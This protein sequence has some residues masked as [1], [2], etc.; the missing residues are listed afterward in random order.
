MTIFSQVL[1]AEDA[2][3]RAIARAP[4]SVGALLLFG[5]GLQ[6]AMLLPSLIAA[7]V[8][9]RTLSGVSVW[10]KPLKFELALIVNFVTLLAL[11]KA[12]PLARPI[13]RRLRI[14][15]LAIAVGS[16]YEI[17]YIALQAARGLASHFNQSTILY[18]TAYG[19]MGV[20]AVCLVAGCFVFGLE[21]AAAPAPRGS[22]GLRTRRRAGP[23][24]RGG[25]DTGYRVCPVFGTSQRRALG[26]RRVFRCE[27]FAD[28]RL[29]DDRWRLARPAFLRDAPHAS[30]AC[31]RTGAGPDRAAGGTQR[32]D[33]RRRTR[34]RARRLHFRA[35]ADGASFV[36]L[37]KNASGKSGGGAERHAATAFGRGPYRERQPVLAQQ[38][39]D[40][41]Q[42]KT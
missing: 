23:L 31:A 12:L 22:E 5:L 30:A 13:S 25:A 26:R 35:S 32:R 36:R 7:A 6:V 10:D 42:A 14:A 40:D 24:P 41:G 38:L 37:G 19:V 39:D 17:G 33:R 18:A 21:F 8:D 3:D 15:A 1:S 2:S 9:V 29:V 20:G 4:A 16:S 28:R 34:R 11:M 27:R